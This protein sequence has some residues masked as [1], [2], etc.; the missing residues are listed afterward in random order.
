MMTQKTLYFVF[1]LFMAIKVVGQP[2]SPA[3]TQAPPPR[4]VESVLPDYELGPGDQFLIGAPQAQEIDQRPFRI[5]SDG[6]IVLPL[7]GSLHAAGLTQRGLETVLTT[8]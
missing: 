8:R 2:P 1:L 7:I 5:D 3:Q 6:N 4:L